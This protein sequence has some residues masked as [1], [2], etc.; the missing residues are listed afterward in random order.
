[1]SIL[2]TDSQSQKTTDYGK[3]KYVEDMAESAVGLM[4]CKKDVFSQARL[5]WWAKTTNTSIESYCQ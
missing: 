2:A 5:D 4:F 3:T 1:L